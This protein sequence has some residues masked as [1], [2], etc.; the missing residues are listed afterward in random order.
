MIIGKGALVK[1][2]PGDP[3]TAA[4][5]NELH[6]QMG[7]A[8]FLKG[9]TPTYVMRPSEQARADALDVGARYATWSATRKESK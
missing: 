4:Q 6:R 2:E 3:L 8:L 9:P 5:R 1:R 7:E